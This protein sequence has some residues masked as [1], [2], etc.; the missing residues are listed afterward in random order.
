MHASNVMAK[1]AANTNLQVL[2]SKLAEGKLTWRKV[3]FSTIPPTSFLV[4]HLKYSR[5]SSQTVLIFLPHATYLPSLNLQQ[6]KKCRCSGC[7]F[8]HHPEKRDQAVDVQD[9]KLPAPAAAAWIAW[10]PPQPCR[11]KFLE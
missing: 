5:F 9:S 10:L 7:P 2:L 1:N 3:Y 8:F 4:Q 11:K 6:P